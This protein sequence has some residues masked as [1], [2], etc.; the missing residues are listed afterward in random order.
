VLIAKRTKPADLS[1]P[2]TTLYENAIKTL[3]LFGETN[4]V[5]L[6][7]IFERANT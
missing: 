1:R 6:R 5:K 7:I 4:L 3:N 2:E